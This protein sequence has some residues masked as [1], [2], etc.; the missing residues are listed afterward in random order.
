MEKR[1]SRYFLDG[2]ELDYSKHFFHVT[3]DVLNKTIVE[4]SPIFGLKE[5]KLK[6]LIS[7][8]SDFWG[9]EG[10]AAQPEY[11]NEEAIEYIINN[12]VECLILSDRIPISRLFRK[13]PNKFRTLKSLKFLQRMNHLKCLHIDFY[14]PFGTLGLGDVIDVDDFTPIENLKNLEC[15]VVPANIE[16]D[17]FVDIDFSRLTKLKEISLLFPE[18]NKTI[19][20]CK[21]ISWVETRYYEKD[22]FLLSNWSRLGYFSAYC[23]NLENLRGLEKLNNLERFQC[24][25]TSKFQGFKEAKSKSIKMF[26]YYTEATKTPTTLEGIS[27]LE[28]VEVL[29]LAGL[30][31]LETIADLPQCRHLKEFRLEDS[32]VPEDI[33]RLLEI[34][35]LKKLIIDYPEKVA[36][37]YPK[38]KP[39]IFYEEDE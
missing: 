32:R 24:Q 19:Y 23:E 2:K 33:E 9:Y 26:F 4:D 18:E 3:S 17:V 14:T 37:K 1:E 22:L 20:Q 13:E 7:I 30:K 11:L 29:A 35:S 12:R 28:N 15:L 25:F 8:D 31:K 39:L 27:G 38:L 21:N 10:V 16:R 6:K 5:Y 36:K 34:K